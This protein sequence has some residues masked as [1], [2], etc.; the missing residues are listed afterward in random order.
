MFHVKHF[1]SIFKGFL[2]NKHVSQTSVKHSV[3]H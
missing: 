2:E 3:K 1:I